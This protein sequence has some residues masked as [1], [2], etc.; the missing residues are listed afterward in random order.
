MS[1]QGGMLDTVVLSM[2]M[3]G[4]NVSPTVLAECTIYMSAVFGAQVYQVYSSASPFPFQQGVFVFPCSDAHRVCW[5][6]IYKWKRIVAEHE[7]GTCSRSRYKSRGQ[8]QR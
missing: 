4:R 8:E 7:H 2:S 5:G 3:V 6:K 1:S